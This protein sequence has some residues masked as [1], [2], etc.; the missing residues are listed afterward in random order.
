MQCK[1]NDWIFSPNSRELLPTFH[2]N[3]P[4]GSHFAQMGSHFAQNPTP[5]PCSLLSSH[6][7]LLEICTFTKHHQPTQ[8]LPFSCPELES[9]Q[10]ELQYGQPAP[11]LGKT[12]EKWTKLQKHPFS[13]Q[14]HPFSSPELESGQNERGQKKI[15]HVRGTHKCEKWH[16]TFLA[17]R[18]FFISLSLSDWLFTEFDKSVFFSLHYIFHVNW[19]NS[20][21]HYNDWFFFPILE[22]FCPLFILIAQMRLILPRWGLILPRIPPPTPIPSSSVTPLF[23]SGDVYIHKLP[24]HHTPKHPFLKTAWVSPS[25]PPTPARL[26]RFPPPRVVLSIEILL[27]DNYVECDWLE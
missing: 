26:A 6:T 22:N 12:F 5:N 1:R 10:N 23:A 27:R 4:D 2:T 21:F 15:I 24:P 20:W 18:P 7:P 16:F 9:G 19:C 11:Q 14:K 17:R 13:T 8:K 3:C 25:K